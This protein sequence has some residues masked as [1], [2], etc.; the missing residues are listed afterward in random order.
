MHGNH[1]GVD[2]SG[3]GGVDGNPPRLQL[4]CE[5]CGV[6]GKGEF[7]FAV[8]LEP[9]VPVWGTVEERGLYFPDVA[10]QRGGGDDT[11]SRVHEGDKLLGE[12]YGAYVVDPNGSFEPV[13]RLPEIFA[14][15]AGVV[16]KCFDRT[17]FVG[18]HFPEMENGVNR[19]Q[20]EG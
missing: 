10:C 5:P 2:D 20:I 16:D 11:A 8:C 14:H 19:G 3:V 1:V 12:E 7:R 18:K 15:D 4:L 9:F 17:A 13:G 6:Q